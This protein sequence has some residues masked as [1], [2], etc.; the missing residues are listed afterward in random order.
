MHPSP[1]LVD[2]LKSDN[3]ARNQSIDQD[4]ALQNLAFADG[5]QQDGTFK[6][7]CRHRFFSNSR[8]RR[9][10]RCPTSCASPIW[11]AKL[12]SSYNFTSKS[13]RIC[14]LHRALHRG[15]DFGVFRSIDVKSKQNERHVDGVAVSSE[16]DL[17]ESIWFAQNQCIEAQYRA[18]I[19]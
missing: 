16:S 6:K 13:G 8:N 3:R 14:C 1:T 12:E 15:L 19:L 2:T 18:S 17:V 4:K 5:Q 11:M 7:D 9:G 10:R